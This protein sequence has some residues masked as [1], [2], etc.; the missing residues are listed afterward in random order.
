MAT[1]QQPTAYLNLAGSGERAAAPHGAATA[2]AGLV[3][4][5]T[6]GNWNPLDPEFQRK[7]RLSR[8]RRA[9]LNGGDVLEAGYLKGGFRRRAAML[10][11]T[12]RDVDG[13]RASHVKECIR[14]IRAWAERKRFRLGYVWVAELQQR[15][16]VHYHLVLWLPK[17]LTIP[18]PDK[19]GWWR[20]GFTNI[21]WARRPVGYLTK[22][23]SKGDDVQKFPR[24][25]RLHGRG[26][27]E[28][29]Q[30]RVVSWWLLPR[31]V[32]AI[33]PEVGTVVRRA[34]GGGWV[35]TETGEWIEPWK[36]P[37]LSVQ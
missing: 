2:A 7:R 17:G 28:L 30:R 33:A 34:V 23:A 25:L 20:H 37:H 24:G 18:K 1:P 32:R 29:P 11:L 35:V 6:R 27:L 8:M 19:Q 5:V 3:E 16:A 4:S 26:G 14:H 9:V 13:W 22:Y 15:G 36:P 10:T 12:Y 21:A 31:Y